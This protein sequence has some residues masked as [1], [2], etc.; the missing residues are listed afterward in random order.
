MVSVLVK[1]IRSSTSC[2]R[3]TRSPRGDIR[4]MPQ[5]YPPWHRV[6]TRETT[7]YETEKSEA[8]LHG[9]LAEVYVSEYIISHLTSMG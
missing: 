8:I 6:G 2:L 3:L 1:N 9:G 4:R 7:S 5:P